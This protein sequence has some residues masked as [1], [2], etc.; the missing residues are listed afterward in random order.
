MMGI[1][2]LALAFLKVFFASRAVLAAENAMLRQQLIVLQRSVKRPQFRKRD[3]V[4]LSWLSKLWSGWR[5]ALLIVQPE[6]ATRW[7][8]QGFK[9]YWRWKSRKKPGRPTVDRK[10]RDLIRRMSRGNPTWGAPRILSEFLL[11][12]HDVAESTVNKYMIRLPDGPLSRSS[13]PSPS[14]RLPASC[15]ETV[16]ASMAST[17]DIGSSTWGLRKC[18]LRPALLRRIRTQSD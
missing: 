2:H 7:H 16:T 17:S 6:S 4:C 14:T 13:K 8:R 9:L 10:I 3:R 15:R 5:S 11:L 12:G 1:V 18:S